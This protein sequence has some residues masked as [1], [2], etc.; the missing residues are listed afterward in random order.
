MLIKYKVMNFSAISQIYQFFVILIF[1]ILIF[2]VRPIIFN[3]VS[4]LLSHSEAMFM[5]QAFLITAYN[6]FDHLDKLI[7]FLDH[8]DVWFYVYI[9]AKVSVPPSLHSIRT[10]NPLAILHS[11]RVEW[12]GQSQILSEL[13]LFEKAFKNTEIEW[14]H[15][16]SGTDFP[17]RPTGEILRFF[18]EALGVDCFMESRPLPSCHADRVERYHFLVKRS[19]QQ[20]RLESIVKSKLSALQVRLGIRRKAP[21]SCGFMFGSNW[22]DLRRNAV[23]ILLDNSKIIRHTTKYTQIANEIYKQ[24]FLQEHDLRIVDD[25]LRY[26]DWT[27]R[28]SSPK[29]LGLADYD[30][31][32][33]SGKLFARKF[34]A[35]DSHL[36][37][38]KICAGLGM[39]DFFV[40]ATDF[41]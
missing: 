3:I 36:L 35:V 20:G 21:V 40:S 11:R 9:D 28:Q 37:R 32:M 24:T 15:L 26:I 10:A 27:A 6:H 12:G 25:N 22:V 18:E 19:S 17:L 14:F 7:R 39:R 8:P 31:I 1:C 4:A 29:S 13:E 23:K 5:Q 2:G 33:D 30:A 41:P 34:D 16:I 38:D